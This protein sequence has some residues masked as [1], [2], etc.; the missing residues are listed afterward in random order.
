MDQLIVAGDML[1]NW[2][3]S[4][5][6]V[7][8]L[9]RQA[10]WNRIQSA[11]EAAEYADEVRA[12][13]RSKFH[14][15]ERTALN[16]RIVGQERVAGVR[17]EKLL[18]ESRPGY[19][20]SAL[21]YL[22]EH[23]SAEHRVP[24]VVGLCGHSE[25][26]KLSDTYRTFCLNLARYGLMVLMPDPVGQGERKQFADTVGAEQFNGN[27]CS[28]H[29]QL[30]KLLTLLGDNLGNWRAWDAVRALDCLCE[31]P[32][33]DT[34]RL[35]VTGNS[36][37]GTLSSYLWALDDRL[38][39]AAPACYIT[40]FRR[41]FDNELPV[42]GEQAIPGLVGAGF[43]MADFL[44]ARAPR[45]VLILAKSN[46]FFDPRGTNES[47]SEVSRIFQ[48]LGAGESAELH[49][50]PGD[51]GFTPGNRQAMY[52]FFCRHA[53]LPEPESEEVLLPT[54][55]VADGCTPDGVVARLPGAKTLPQLLADRAGECASRPFVADF[56]GAP[57]PEAPDFK[58]MR[59]GWQCDGSAAR[60]FAVNVYGVRTE[61]GILG[62]L[63]VRSLAPVNLPTPGDRA[64]LV[65][66]D[67]NAES[68]LE[69][70]PLGTFVL[71]VRGVG[72]S[73]PQTSDRNGTV[74]APYGGEFFYYATGRMLGVSLF[75][76]RVH[77]VLAA[78]KLLRERGARH[79]TLIGAGLGV[80]LAA[81]AA[82]AAPELC[83]ELKL[84]EYTL[85][86]DLLRSGVTRLPASYFG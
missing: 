61:P 47:F 48:L 10:R 14:F 78:L 36:G 26:G 70:Y 55:G 72:K 86:A 41:N 17:V 73:F 84:D 79:L 46:D 83:D 49:F 24:G 66:A 76:G 64:V 63:H 19:P 58:V 32:E 65:V 74:F 40:S 59:N 18:F 29:N 34:T 6:D 62:F 3:A 33:C 52:R 25:T 75:A 42:D 13:V 5:F 51:H 31:R 69:R 30:D 22:P 54:G 38:T 21:L 71:D 23:A 53:G 37:G 80:T 27:C 56:D 4:K 44:I 43:E 16:T 20:V 68:E 9:T 35:G 81:A 39:M 7:L 12:L 8:A 45:P 85:P 77:D 2:Y 11:A 50:E 60:S 15:P 67:R 82:Q 57:P 28:E 1:Q